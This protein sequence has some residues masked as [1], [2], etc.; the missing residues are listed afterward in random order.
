MIMVLV[1][2]NLV[3]RFP[4]VASICILQH[5]TY[6]ILYG[7]KNIHFMAPIDYFRYIKIQ[8]DSEA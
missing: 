6:I 1:F 8:L 5:L 7:K 4:R 3:H 2:Q